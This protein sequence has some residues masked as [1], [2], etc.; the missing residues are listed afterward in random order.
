MSAA[1]VEMLFADIV[2]ERGGTD[3]LSATALAPYG[4]RAKSWIS[5]TACHP[6]RVQASLA[7][8]QFG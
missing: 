3:A 5:L 7:C 8:T 4:V 2:G 1:D 6:N